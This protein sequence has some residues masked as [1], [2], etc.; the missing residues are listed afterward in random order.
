MH[1]P[2]KQW[3][4]VVGL[5]VVALSTIGCGDGGPA[6][7]EVRGKVLLDG[8]PMTKGFVTTQPSAGRGAN[9]AIQPDGSFELS[10]GR[11]PGALVGPHAVAVVAYE[12]PGAEGAEADMGKLLVPQRYTSPMSSQLSIEVKEDGD[13]APVLELSAK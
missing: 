6:F 1:L 5:T 13:N 4:S 12:N 7:A 11:V 2:R 10:S 8:K 3:W 9:G